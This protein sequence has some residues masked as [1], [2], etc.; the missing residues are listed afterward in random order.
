MPPSLP[1]DT[2]ELPLIARVEY[3][4]LETQ[5]QH[6]STTA[7]KLAE[8]NSELKRIVIMEA[9]PCGLDPV[10]V[11]QVTAQMEALLV[12]KARLLQE[13]D[14]LLRANT[15]LQVCLY[16]AHFHAQ[17]QGEVHSLFY[18]KINTLQMALGHCCCID[19]AC[20]CTTGAAGIHHAPTGRRRCWFVGRSR[21]Q[22]STGVGRGS[23]SGRPE[24]STKVPSFVLCVRSSL[25]MRAC[26]CDIEML[27]VNC[28]NLHFFL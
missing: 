4:E 17:E 6:T 23:G 14:R 3:E 10:A 13:N 21:W 5:L 12:E 27:F 1:P 20:Y 11:Q 24:L 18:L 26:I 16:A 25:S 15:G 19:Y 7:S 28:R 22:R 2:F 9:D 8:E